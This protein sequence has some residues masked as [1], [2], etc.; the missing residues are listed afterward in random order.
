MINQAIKLLKIN[1]KKVQRKACLRIT[2]AIQGTSRQRLNDELGLISL[3]KKCWYNKPVFFHK[4]VN[5]LI[6]YYLQSYIKVIRDYS[7]KSASIRKQKP[8]LS[9][10]KNFEKVFVLIVLMNRIN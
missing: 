5:E 8:F 10:S 2:G 4:I 6:P 1:F 9:R 3:S 7:L